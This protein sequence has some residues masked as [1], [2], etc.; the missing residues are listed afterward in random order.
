VNERDL[1]RK[2]LA[3]ITL[4]AMFLG[5]G[6]FGFGNLMRIPA[7]FVIFCIVVYPN[8]T[9]MLHRSYGKVVAISFMLFNMLYLMYGSVS[10]MLSMDT[11]SGNGFGM[12][13]FSFLNW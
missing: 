7:Y 1:F 6:T 4:I 13:T 5:I 11:S 9:A 8:V 12:F 2:Y 10:N 3:I